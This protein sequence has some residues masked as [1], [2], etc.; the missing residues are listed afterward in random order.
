VEAGISPLDEALGL[1]GSPYSARV[2]GW[3]V[4]LGAALPFAQ[5]AVL[6]QD[7]T[8]IQVSAATVRRQTEA[9][10]ASAVAM[11]KA[12]VERLEQE[13]PLPPVAPDRLV[14][15]VDG[16]MVPLRQGIWAEMKLVSI[17]EPEQDS[18]PA[19]ATEA[20]EAA[21][22]A[23]VRTRHLS[24]FARGD[25]AETFGRQALGELHR[26][27][28]ETAGAVAAVQDGAVWLQ[29]FVDCHR[30]DAL[31]I[32]DWPHA[33][34]RLT[35]MAEQVFGVDTP[36]ARRVADRLRHWL[37]REGPYRVLAVLSCWE[38]HHPALGADRA[39]LRERQAHMQY[40][41]F[42][43]HGWP[44]GSGPAESAHKSVMQARLK[45]AGM[46]W[47]RQHVNPLLAVR[48]LESNGRWITE[49]PALLVEHRAR[50][51]R[52]RRARQ[53]VRRLAR[54]PAPPPPPTPAARLPTPHPWCRY[55]VPLSA[56]K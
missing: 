18:R 45:R 23:G 13:G 29:G 8:G 20:A 26:R 11:A 14:V 16:A 34:Q 21:R 44:V 15:S 25:D 46:H 9:V 7:L 3:Q 12:E 35:A 27:G 36:R 6:L 30:P 4:R 40:P 48:L 28:L 55:G 10:G 52:Q 19:E 37:W 17:G 50:C 43:E 38:R 5:A 1:S 2:L 22:T 42:R 53:Q 33:A 39:Y 49:G 56:K 32:V 31:R 41:V 51:L 24:Y 47:A 54:R